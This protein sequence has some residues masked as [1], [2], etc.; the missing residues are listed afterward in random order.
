MKL[1][2]NSITSNE[3]EFKNFA[4]LKTGDFF[5]YRKM[6]YVKTDRALAGGLN[7][8]CFTD[9]FSKKFSDEIVSVAK[10]A[11]ISLEF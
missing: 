3:T 1:L 6:L 9:R 10:S 7:A 4:D 8:Y 2:I 11:T 5:D